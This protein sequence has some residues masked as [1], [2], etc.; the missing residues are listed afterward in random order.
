MSCSESAPEHFTC[1]L[2]LELMSHPIQHKTTKHNFERGAIMEWIYFGKATCPL[3]R[4]TL[5]PNDFVANAELK[6]E[7]NQ[8]K[9]E[10]KITVCGDDDLD[11]SC[12]AAL[13]SRRVQASKTQ[14]SEAPPSDLKHL[15]SLRNK[16]LQNRDAR[17]QSCLRRHF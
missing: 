10:H 3:T 17:V 11:C 13:E 12:N 5:H 9:K 14:N 2:T 4:I 1:P 6:Q 16:V 8:W 15:M 7:I